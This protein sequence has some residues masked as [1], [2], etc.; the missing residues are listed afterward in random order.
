MTTT[1]IWK[2]K[3]GNP[4]PVII[5][6]SAHIKAAYKLC[7]FRVYF[8]REFP[9]D[10]E[11]T[12]PEHLAQLYDLWIDLPTAQKW[13][14][15]FEQEMKRRKERLTKPVQ[16]RFMQQI[17]NRR[18]RKQESEYEFKKIFGYNI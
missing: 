15:I 17:H 13:I 11:N 9:N 2:D 1:H 6:D 4:H 7:C 12:Q 10:P 5:M 16:L 8:D 14:P 3:R 18:G